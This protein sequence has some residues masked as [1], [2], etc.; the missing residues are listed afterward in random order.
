MDFR[1]VSEHPPYGVRDTVVSGTPSV[2]TLHRILHSPS[3]P[4]NLW[5]FWKR[6]DTINKPR[7]LPL[8]PSRG[9]VFVYITSSG[10]TRQGPA[11]KRAVRPSHRIFFTNYAFKRRGG[12]LT[13]ACSRFGGGLLKAFVVGWKENTRNLLSMGRGSGAVRGGVSGTRDITSGGDD[14]YGLSHLVHLRA[15]AGRPEPDCNKSSC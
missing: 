4:V 2:R 6:K 1:P 8:L 9:F 14:G 11:A 5:P 12:S 10:G 15:T 7:L 13:L 3:A